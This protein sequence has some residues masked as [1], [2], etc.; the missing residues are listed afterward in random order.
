MLSKIVMQY[1][2]LP[3]KINQQWLRIAAGVHWWCC[4][5]NIQS[6]GIGGYHRSSEK[7]YIN[8]F[9]MCCVLC[10]GNTT[11]PEHGT[12]N[13]AQ[14]SAQAVHSDSCW[15]IAYHGQYWMGHVRGAEMRLADELKEKIATMDGKYQELI[16]Q[17]Q[18]IMS[19]TA[20]SRPGWIP[21]CWHQCWSVTCR[22]NMHLQLISVG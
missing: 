3:I 14:V 7:W 9:H 4:Q 15:H 12:C 13:K 19:Q 11:C 10:A 21:S 8:Y 20:P 17:Q 22:R 6:W 1:K 5:E 2:Y 16:S 18:D